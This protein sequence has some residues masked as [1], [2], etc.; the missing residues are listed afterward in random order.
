MIKVF[1]LILN[2]FESIP[3]YGVFVKKIQIEV[4]S[5]GSWGIKI[6]HIC[7]RFTFI[8][9]GNGEELLLW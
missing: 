7:T 2:I 8:R 1:R 6:I 3:S 5:L 4:D 9:T